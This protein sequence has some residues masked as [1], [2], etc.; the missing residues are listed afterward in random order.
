MIER[1]VDLAIIGGG[2]A[3]LAAAIKAKELGIGNVLILERDNQLGGI[4]PQCIHSGFGLHYFGKDLTGPEFAERLINRVNEL[5]IEAKLNTMVIE[6][7]NDKT[8]IAVN[9]TDGLLKIKPKAV[10]LAMGCRER[11]RSAI[12]LPGT[13]PAGIFTAG[14]AQRLINIEGYL[15]GKE[16]VILGSGDVGLIMARRF[17]LEGAKVKAVAEIMPYPGGLPRNV[18]QCLEDFGIPLY[19]SHTVIDIKGKNRVESVTIAKVDKNFK[20]IPGTEKEI[21]CDTLV[22]SVGLIPENELSKGAGVEID[23]RTGGAFVDENLQTNIQGIFACGNVLVVYDLVDYVV[24]SAEIAAQ[25]AKEYLENGKL[26]ESKIKVEHDKT[27]RFVVPHYVS[28]QKDVIFVMRVSE[29]MENVKLMIE[30]LGIKITQP[31]VVPS[32]MIR[33]K[34]SRKLISKAKDKITFRI[35]KG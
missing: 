20:P 32:E 31:H 17:T 12:Q 5:G 29:P 24:E 33:L 21:K 27:I 19:L 28:G 13:R 11:S 6:L 9:P 26:P 22:L 14:T 23:P 30:E 10:I 3:G 4:L 2:P 8:I 16:V 18:V 7:N 1:N 25:G 34:L 15:P 35:V